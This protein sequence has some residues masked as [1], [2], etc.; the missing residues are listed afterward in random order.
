MRFKS[1]AKS[2]YGEMLEGGAILES[3]LNTNFR[4][5][6]LVFALVSPVGTDHG[7]VVNDLAQRLVTVGYQVETINVSKN[8]ITLFQT[9]EKT[10]DSEFRRIEYFMDLGNKARRESDNNAI[11]ALGIVNL[12]HAN[13]DV[14]EIVRCDVP[15]NE[16]KEYSPKPKE[17]VAYIV[18]SLKHPDEIKKLREIYSGGIYV[19]SI[20]S[21]TE[22]RVSYLKENKRMKTEEA[23]HLIDRD[24]SEKLGHGQQTRDAF[25]LADFF[26]ALDEDIDKLKNSI[27][28]I[29]DLIFGNPY[30]TPTF[31]EYAMYLAFTAALRSADLS[32]QVGAVIGRNEEI[33][34]TGANDCPRANGGLYWPFFDR[35]SKKVVDSPKG[36]DYTRGGDINKIQIDNIIKD[37]LSHLPE[38]ISKD[39]VETALRESKLKD[40]TEFGRVVHAEMEALLFCSRNNLSTKD[41]TLYCTTFPCHNCAKHIIAAGI[42]KVVYIEPYP[43]SLALD[44]HEDAISTNEKSSDLV[45][46]IPFVGVGPRKFFD[47]FSMKQSDGYELKRKEE[48]KTIDWQPEEKTARLQMYPFSY[49]DKEVVAV[50]QFNKQLEKINDNKRAKLE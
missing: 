48:N 25:Q 10:H 44:F 32:R 41:A 1:E 7:L 28:R 22:R 3:L 34:A 20:A 13:R 14:E 23:S 36:R 49:L 40:I 2:G 33:I 12:I 27:W 37:V 21:S 45:N 35:E 46:F 38:H 24:Q 18:N 6:E 11:L 17:K 43:K 16:V 9:E 4:G 26:I 5:T 47:L 15:G 31:D 19:I 8:I 42:K 30:L 29:V 50:D 39:E